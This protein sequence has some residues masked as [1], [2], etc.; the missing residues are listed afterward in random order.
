[1]APRYRDIA[2][3]LLSTKKYPD[4]VIRVRYEIAT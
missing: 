4:G 2:L 3:R 1:V